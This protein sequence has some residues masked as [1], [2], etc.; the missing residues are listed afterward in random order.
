MSDKYVSH[1]GL[2]YFWGKLKTLL[3]DKQD[4]IVV[5]ASTVSQSGFSS[6][7]YLAGSR[8]IFPQAP[9]VG[10]RYKLIFDVTKTTAGTATP[11]I[12]IRVG[13]AGTVSDA[14]VATLTFGAGTAAVDAG[15]FEVICSFRSV[16]ASAVMQCISRLTTNLTTTGLSNAKK[17]ILATSSGFNST[18]ASLGIGVSYKAGT[19]AAHTIQLVSAELIM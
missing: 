10:T 18:T 1:D 12:Y 7:T 5:N 4:K 15:V 2:S 16:G 6:D 14:A 13:T 17:A 9:K 11:I 3:S 19:S 8:I